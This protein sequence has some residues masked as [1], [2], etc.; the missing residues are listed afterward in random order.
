MRRGVGDKEVRGASALSFVCCPL[1]LKSAGDS[2][3]L[4]APDL[5]DIWKTVWAT[6][7]PAHTYPCLSSIQALG[8]NPHTE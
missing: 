7:W 8:P 2:L 5:T 6:S 3:A 4:S 1:Y